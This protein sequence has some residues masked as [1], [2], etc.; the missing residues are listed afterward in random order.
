MTDARLETPR[1]L[2][3]HL[4]L[5]EGRDSSPNPNRPAGLCAYWLSCI[6][7]RWGLREVPCGKD[8][9]I[10]GRRNQGPRLRYLEKRETYYITWTEHGRS[11]ERSTGTSDREQAEIVFAE[12]LHARARRD[13]PTDPSEMLVTD[14]L[15]YYAS[16]RGPKVAAPDVML[17]AIDMLID[18]GKAGR[19]RTYGRKRALT[20]VRSGGVRQAL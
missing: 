7:P 5:S 13:S 2:A 10:V 9:E 19:S 6:Y 4:G 11:R 18:F 20:T 16:E 1:Q 17:R 12:F 14:I 3:A 8:R 15:T